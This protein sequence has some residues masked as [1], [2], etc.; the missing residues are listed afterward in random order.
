[1]ST[2]VNRDASTR[3]ST[4]QKT[5]ID[6]SNPETEVDYPDKW[7]SSNPGQKPSTSIPA[8]NLPDANLKS[9]VVGGIKTASLTLKTAKIFL[10]R[11]GDRMQDRLTKNW[12]SFARDI[13]RA[14]DTI[15]PWNVVTVTED[16]EYVPTESLWVPRDGANEAD[17]LN[18]T[19]R[20]IALYIL[21]IYR[22]SRV[23]NDA[24][25]RDLQ[26]RIELQLESEGG[27]GM[28]LDGTSNLY[29]GWGKNRGYLKMVAAIDMFLH[30]FRD[31][32]D[33]ILRMGSL[34]SRFRD[35][36]GLLSFG[37]AQS[38]LNLEP[39][40]LMDWVFITQMGD[41]VDRVGVKDQEIGD[42][43]S[44]FPYQS[45]LGLVL[46]SAYSSN[47][48]PY[49]FHWIHL[50]GALLGHKRSIHARFTFE[51]SYSDIC[52]NAVLVFWVFS[53]GG[54]LSPQFEADGK[55]Y[56]TE[57]ESVSNAGEELDPTDKLWLETQGR[58]PQTWFS[59][60]KGNGFKIPA[61]IR[62]VIK[63]QQGKIKEVRADTIGEY[64]KEQ[65]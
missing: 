8:C 15:K 65:Y 37:Y 14:N 17:P 41:E 29:A 36:A 50:I 56:A 46:R 2:R 57:I 32:E 30:Y 10:Y 11:Y 40:D 12:S 1:M 59:L 6:F 26:G 24:Y 7:F 52:L 42:R 49:L 21:C 23:V 51:G 64:V 18:W 34:V 62:R 43:Y 9:A 31:H 25:R 38:I 19:D 16:G 55:M 20:S 54:E 61:G 39:A 44:Y 48:N 47:A 22:L 13:G 27:K 4:G 33:G 3:I 35:C 60:L 45:D 53:R 5:K 28:S 58:D 63:Q